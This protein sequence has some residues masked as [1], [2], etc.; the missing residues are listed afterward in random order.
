MSLHITAQ[1]RGK[2]TEWNTLCAG[3]TIQQQHNTRTYGRCH[4]ATCHRQVF[5]EFICVK[6]SRMCVTAFEM[7]NRFTANLKKMAFPA[8]SSPPANRRCCMLYILSSVNKRNEWEHIETCLQILL[9]DVCLW[10]VGSASKCL[11]IFK[12]YRKRQSPSDR[13]TAF[14]YIGNSIHDAD[15]YIYCGFVVIQED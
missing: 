11:A 5:P 3:K 7:G 13:V 9:Y 14:H 15:A 8:S 10:F 2:K 12:E 1:Q 4:V 6:L